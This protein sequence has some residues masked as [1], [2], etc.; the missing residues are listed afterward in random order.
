MKIKALV[1][2][3]KDGP[4]VLQEIDLGE[5]ERG[6]ALI[7]IVACGVCHTDAITR[8]GDMPMPFPSVLGHEGAGVVE[9]VGPG[10][11]EVVAAVARAS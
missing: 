3:R 7:R 4:F 6:E 1:V 8:A 10:V 5:P 2:D 9:R 11:T